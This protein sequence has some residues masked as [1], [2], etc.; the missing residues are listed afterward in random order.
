M[1]EQLM[2]SGKLWSV[3]KY[4]FNDSIIELPSSIM[5]ILIPTITLETFQD[6]KRFV[7]EVEDQDRLL[8]FIN[9]LVLGYMTSNVN[10]PLASLNDLANYYSFVDLYL[11]PKLTYTFNVKTALKNLV[12]E[13]VDSLYD[14]YAYLFLHSDN[15]DVTFFNA[16]LHAIHLGHIIG[17]YAPGTCYIPRTPI[18]VNIKETDS[19]LNHAMS[20]VIKNAVITNKYFNNKVSQDVILI[21]ES[22]KVYPESFILALKGEADPCIPDEIVHFSPTTPNS[23][24]PPNSIFLS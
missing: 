12:R 7:I 16:M 19:S 22:M 6:T 15:I 17:Y 3:D 24:N 1:L 5:E 14:V 8:L 2:L 4:Q 18:L 13:Q 23:I 21:L 20:I 9:Y 10:I 11:D